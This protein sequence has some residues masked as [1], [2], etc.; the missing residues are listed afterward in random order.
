MDKEQLK[1][2]YYYVGPFIYKNKM[3][4]IF[5]TKT[6]YN[7]VFYFDNKGELT[8]ASP[9]EA[10]EL[11]NILTPDSKTLFD[12]ALTIEPTKPN[13]PTGPKPP[14]AKPNIATSTEK[15]SLAKP[16][17]ESTKF[18]F[19][20]KDSSDKVVSISTI[21]ATHIPRKN[22]PA[23][24]VPLQKIQTL[25]NNI[26]RLKRLGVSDSI[27][28]KAVDRLNGYNL[29]YDD[30]E[31]GRMS[32][33]FSASGYCSAPDKTV[34]ILSSN[35]N[36]PSDSLSKPHSQHTL[37]H[38]FFHAMASENDYSGVKTP[39]GA[40]SVF[41]EIYTE[42][43]TGPHE[44]G[45]YS[46]SEYIDLYTSI[47]GKEL[48]AKNIEAHL[49]N[50]PERF[51][52]LLAKQIGASTD[53]I[54]QFS[55]VMDAHLQIQKHF[56]YN[57]IVNEQL[58]DVYKQTEQYYTTM[59]HICKLKKDGKSINDQA[60]EELAHKFGT[61]V[62]GVI[63]N[64]TSMVMGGFSSDSMQTETKQEILIDMITSTK[65]GNDIVHSIYEIFQ[66]SKSPLTINSETSSTLTEQGLNNSIL[67]PDMENF[68]INAVSPK[69]L[70]QNINS[71]QK[72]FSPQA[73]DIIQ[74]IVLKSDFE[75][76]SELI[77][78]ISKQNRE[79]FKNMAVKT[80]TGTHVSTE[81]IRE[82]YGILTPEEQVEVI[83]TACKNSYEANKNLP[84]TEEVLDTYALYDIITK[85]TSNPLRLDPNPLPNK[86]ITDLIFNTITKY[87]KSGI[88]S[89][90]HFFKFLYYG[91]EQSEILENFATNMLGQE[92]YNE[93][94]QSLDECIE[95]E[96]YDTALFIIQDERGKLIEEQE[97]NAPEQEQ[98]NYSQR[99]SEM[100]QTKTL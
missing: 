16:Y 82:I 59:F 40:F 50:D 38:E 37:S 13:L 22:E 14:R 64:I 10:Q 84:A 33:Q 55:F 90:M 28:K 83:T 8:L 87:D 34:K 9:K 11:T 43:L 75:N 80:I 1:K 4:R 47:F 30:I 23:L 46:Y 65:Y 27:I 98:A 67:S 61:S 76:K 81:L 6:N 15:P 85:P 68:L 17:S 44:D 74:G 78:Q 95:D 91:Q 88:M 73:L 53:D 52:E 31:R 29:I 57:Q 62:D 60:L 45:R 42:L 7:L 96:D 97:K 49:E 26:E 72:N 63:E 39:N 51:C 12:L 93:I 89:D 71:L 19:V 25:S 36:E 18:N 48:P 100:E 2:L 79:V 32:S 66:K 24:T 35:P 41:N 5:R 3:V 54:K 92:K 20:L 58:L 21:T 70:L 99:T 56:D 86:E 77:S 69:Y 94:K